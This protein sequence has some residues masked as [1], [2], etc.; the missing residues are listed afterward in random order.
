MQHHVAAEKGEGVDLIVADQAEME[1]GAHRIS[2]G[3]QSHAKLIDV[4]IQQRIVNQRRAGS[5]L[6]HIKI[7]HLQFLINR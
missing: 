5:Q 3:H 6:A 4:L 2:M 1:R 7:A